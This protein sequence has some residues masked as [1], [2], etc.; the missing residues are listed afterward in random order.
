[1]ALTQDTLGSN[2]RLLEARLELCPEELI[3]TGPGQSGALNRSLG[4]IEDLHK[5]WEALQVFGCRHFGVLARCVVL[6]SC[7][8]SGKLQ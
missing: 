7:R 1:M 5:V 3:V 6:A 4:Q 8:V 2:G